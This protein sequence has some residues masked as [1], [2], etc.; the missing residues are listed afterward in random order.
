MDGVKSVEEDDDEDDVIDL[1][2]GAAV[3]NLQCRF[4]T[5][6]STTVCSSAC[7]KDENKSNKMLK[8]SSIIQCKASI[9]A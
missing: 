4:F 7:Y 5:H 1:T 9:I 8:C 3:E 2:A 6:A